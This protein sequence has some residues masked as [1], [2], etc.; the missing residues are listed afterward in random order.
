[1]EM[2]IDTEFLYKA[3]KGREPLEGLGIGA[4]EY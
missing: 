2:R 4:R 1:L 3:F